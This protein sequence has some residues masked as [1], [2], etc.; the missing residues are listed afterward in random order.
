MD[1]KPV[2]IVESGSNLILNLSCRHSLN[3]INSCGSMII[4]YLKTSCFR[5]SFLET[6]LSN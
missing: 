2:K 3:P 6:M 1:N 5:N 4:I